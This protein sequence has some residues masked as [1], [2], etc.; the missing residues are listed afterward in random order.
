[1]KKV[2][3][4]LS[5]VLSFLMMG[6]SSTKWIVQ[7][8]N[9]HLETPNKDLIVEY[10]EPVKVWAFINS[11]N[12]GTKVKLENTTN[13]IISIDLDASSV[14]YRTSEGIYTSRLFYSYN[15]LSEM[16][17][18]LN[19]KLVIPPKTT[20]NV[21]L[22]PLDFMSNKIYKNKVVG[23]NINHFYS[24]INTLQLVLGYSINNQ[25][26]LKNLIVSYDLESVQVPK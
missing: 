5:L 18:L 1:M 25:K 22:Y 7:A 6:C 21:D 9:T 24:S 13:K 3:L 2:L 19:K 26:D 23:I 11:S 15:F 14:T 20:I 12:C 8:K 4:I 17:E 10:I 16:P